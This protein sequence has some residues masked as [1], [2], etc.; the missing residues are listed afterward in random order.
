MI[1]VSTVWAIILGWLG[2]NL[3]IILHELGHFIVAK[4]NRVE[5]EEFGLGLPPR[6]ASWTIGRGFWRCRYS[7]NWLPIGGFVR[8]KGERDGSQEPGSYRAAR[9]GVKLKILL[10]GVGVN[11]LVGALVLTVLALIGLPR[12]LPIEQFF[13]DREQWSLP[14]DTY[15]SQRQVRLWAVS[16]DSVLVQAGLEPGDQIVAINR[17]P[18]ASQSHLITELEAQAGGPVELDYIHNRQLQSAV[19]SL[20]AGVEPMT[21]LEADFDE[22]VFEVHGWSAP[23]TGV[24]V[25]AQYTG[26]SFEGLFQAVRALISGSPGEAKD[27]VSGPVGIIHVI[28]ITLEQSWLLVIMILA[29]ISLSLAVMNLLPIPPLDGGQALLTIWSEKVTK[30]PLTP[31]IEQA[32]QITGT[33]ILLVLIGL[34][35]IVDVLRV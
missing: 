30:R 1:R 2:L 21:G 10:A 13:P 34:V 25:A 20:E 29:L 8:L 35:T 24:V 16:P 17:Q 19:I 28:K 23:L 4:R 12:L 11:F 15:I 33:V 22:L 3:L 26:I 6:L 14:A 27:L 31:E 32:V 5:V 18:V 9:F 7:L